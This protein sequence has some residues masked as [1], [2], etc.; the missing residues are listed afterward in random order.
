MTP[1]LFAHLIESNNNWRVVRIPRQHKPPEEQEPLFIGDTASRW[2]GD[3]LVV[4]T[5]SLDERTWVK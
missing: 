4:E 5:V 1:N 3:T 2:E